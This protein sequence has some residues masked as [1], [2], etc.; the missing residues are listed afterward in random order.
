MTLSPEQID[1]VRKYIEKNNIR[2]D[3]LRDDVIDHLCCSVEYKIDNGKTF[4][5]SLEEALDELAPEGLYKLELETILILQSK[6]ILM[7]KFMYF[8]GLA[9]AISMSMGFTFKILHM[10][11][12]DELFNYGFVTFALVFLPMSAYNIFKGKIKRSVAEKLRVVL[13]FISAVFVG[14]AV[15]FKMMHYPWVD[16]LLLTGAAIFSFGF[17]PSLFYSMYERSLMLES[18]N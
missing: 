13:G 15:F 5:L 9:T 6:N 14:S 8:I 3:T 2:I 16:G 1:R 17:L 11:G 7:R 10:P 4:Q 18:R 12:A